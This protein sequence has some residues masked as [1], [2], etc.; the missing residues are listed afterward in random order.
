MQTV[1]RRNMS[2]CLGFCGELKNF[3]L[4]STIKK[5][6]DKVTHTKAAEKTKCDIS[7][8]IFRRDSKKEV[9]RAAFSLS[10]KMK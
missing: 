6:F 1:Y 5:S 9:F 7:A 3:S 8:V 2:L 4:A 10:E